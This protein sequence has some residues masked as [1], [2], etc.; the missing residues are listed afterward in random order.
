MENNNFNNFSDP[1]SDK[2]E[3]TIKKEK[4]I[5]LILSIAF[6]VLLLVVF[7]D[8]YGRNLLRSYALKQLNVA[9][10]S[11]NDKKIA[12]VNGNS[13]ST[14][15]NKEKNNN[16]QPALATVDPSLYAACTAKIA[17]EKVYKQ[18]C[19]ALSADDSVKKACKKV[20]DGDKK[21]EQPQ[22]GDPVK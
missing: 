14:P 2:L 12:P 8:L 22:V 10:E 3:K 17:D 7:W 1:A 5:I 20:V 15:A 16:K 4:K 11:V 19:D 9:E 6:I 18:C 13:T 21:L